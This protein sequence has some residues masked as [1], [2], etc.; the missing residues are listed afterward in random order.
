M[1]EEGRLSRFLTEHPRF[2]RFLGDLMTKR[3]YAFARL[4]ILF[5]AIQLIHLLILLPFA[6]PNLI[7]YGLD[8]IQ[9]YFE[10]RH[11]Y[12]QTVKDFKNGN[13]DSEYLDCLSYIGDNYESAYYFMSCDGKYY[14]GLCGWNEELFKI[15]GEQRITNG[16]AMQYVVKIRKKEK[17]ISSVKY[18]DMIKCF[19]NC[20][21]FTDEEKAAYIAEA[22]EKKKKAIERGN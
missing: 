11:D 4:G 5:L 3:I 7:A 19:G 13:Y 12:S 1:K 17:D 10:T 6:L 2:D 18:D 20:T 15:L 14:G 8:G 16:A 22:K 21:L 9:V